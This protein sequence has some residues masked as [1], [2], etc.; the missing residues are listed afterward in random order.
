M[1][2]HFQKHLR[3]RTRMPRH[4]PQMLA[5]VYVDRG[6]PVASMKITMTDIIGRGFHMARKIRPHPRLTDG[7]LHLGGSFAEI[8]TQRCYF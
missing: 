2:P 1:D 7:V 8:E 5:P 6:F 4:Q 3:T